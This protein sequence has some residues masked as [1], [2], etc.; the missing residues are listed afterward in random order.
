MW[1]MRYELSGGAQLAADGGVAL[2]LTVDH[3]CTAAAS[4]SWALWEKI[5]Y[6]P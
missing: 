4:L 6:E 1:V 3:L 5:K 2:A